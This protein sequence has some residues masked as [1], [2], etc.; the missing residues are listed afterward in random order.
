MVALLA[1]AIQPYLGRLS[2][3]ALTVAWALTIA[4]GAFAVWFAARF[5]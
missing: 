3:H 5:F 4:G 2:R 1:Y